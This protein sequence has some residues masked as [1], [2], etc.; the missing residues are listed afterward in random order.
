MAAPQYTTCVNPEDYQDI[1]LTAEEITAAAGLVVA[2]IS[3]VLAGPAGLVGL[4]I[5]TVAG[6]SA[7]LKAC[8][9]MLGG[10]LVCLGRDCRRQKEL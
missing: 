5:S 1:D 7:L 3:T 10:K 6:M 8:D 4:F 2:I 9:Y